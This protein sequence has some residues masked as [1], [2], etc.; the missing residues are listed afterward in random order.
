M[1]PPV[2]T[3][4]SDLLNQYGEACRKAGH[5]DVLNTARELGKQATELRSQI[6]SLFASATEAGAR[7]ERDKILPLLKRIERAAQGLG[8]YIGQDGQL[9]KEVQKVIRGNGET[10][11][12]DGVDGMVRYFENNPNGITPIGFKKVRERSEGGTQ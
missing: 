7:I 2:M 5:A 9:L 8:G 3:N 11:D 12:Q 4:L 1:Q 6:T 10:I